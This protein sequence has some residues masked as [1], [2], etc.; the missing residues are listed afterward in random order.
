MGNMAK[1]SRCTA[2]QTRKHKKLKYAII[3]V[4]IIIKTPKLRNIL[5]YFLIAI[6]SA[7]NVHVSKIMWFTKVK[8]VKSASLPSFAE[9]TSPLFYHFI[10]NLLKYNRL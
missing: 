7:D 9:T 1:N 6:S 3:I 10:Q 8:N 4:I 2:K 5:A